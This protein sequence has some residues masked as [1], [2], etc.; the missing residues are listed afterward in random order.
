VASEQECRDAL[1]KLAER[2]SGVDEHDRKRVALDRSVSCTLTDLGTTFSGELRDGHI[3]GVTT[4]AAP[5]AQI[6]LTMASDDLVALT[7]GELDFAKS[8]L[9]GRVKI[10]ASVMDLLKLRSLL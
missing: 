9:S 6:R 2:L 7:H 5:K 1:D 4:E 10:D 3:V 8:W